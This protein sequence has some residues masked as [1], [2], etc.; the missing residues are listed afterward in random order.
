M[1]KLNLAAA[2]AA[3]VLAA[4][5]AAAAT[6][7]L[8]INLYHGD[9]NGNCADTRPGSGCS[10]IGVTAIGG[11][12]NP[13]LNDTA[14]KAI[15][16]APGSYYLFGNPYAG[17][18]FMT[19]GAVISSM[20]T[21][22]AGDA[23]SSYLMMGNTLVPD[24]SVAGVTLFDFAKYGVK[25]ST[26]GLTAD[27]MSFGYPPGA[28]KPDGATDFVLRLDYLVPGS[29]VPEPATWAMMIAGFGLAGATLRRRRTAFA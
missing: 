29:A 5:P 2:A 14:T 9:S 20:I 6:P 13:F 11:T 22:G 21:V 23:G 4:Q 24:L 26:T 8:S 19:Q 28:F 1:R 15:S 27:R 3:L 18:N 10:P 25:I 7:L 12:A 16:L 17:T